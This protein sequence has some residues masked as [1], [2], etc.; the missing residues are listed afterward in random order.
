MRTVETKVFTFDELT[1]TAKNNAIENTR[2]KYY[3]YNDFLE[4]A[5]DDCYLLEPK[6][7]EL[8]KLFGSNYK[9]PLLKNNRSIYL[10]LDRNRYID[11]S[12]AI[13][14][15][16]S[17]QF[18]TWLGINEIDFLDEDGYFVIDYEIGKDTI[19]FN[20]NNWNFEL[21]IEQE[22]ILEDAKE[23]FE[24]HCEDIL[25]RIEEDYEYRFTDEA[26]MEDINANDF[27]FLE[28]GDRF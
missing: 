17:E 15:Q 16:D 20:L 22:K 3:E 7:Q 2:Q 21:S 5:I 23:K 1:E 26:I 28:N 27:E 25:D 13:E 10:S 19:E 6:Q 18:L 4:W 8:E 11:I 9:F 12:N 14:V 24:N